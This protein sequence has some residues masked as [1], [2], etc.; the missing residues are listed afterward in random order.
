MLS[1]F[2]GCVQWNYMSIVKRFMWN[3]FLNLINHLKLALNI[4]TILKW[5]QFVQWLWWLILFS[6]N[7]QNQFKLLYYLKKMLTKS[8]SLSLSLTFVFHDL[9]FSY[10]N[11]TVKAFIFSTPTESKGV[12]LKKQVRFRWFSNFDYS[13]TGSPTL[14][15]E[16]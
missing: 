14:S 7:H 12:W 11:Y 6:N 4:S 10:S 9:F 3:H 1:T 8:H 13:T 5:N 15:R 16:Q 2:A